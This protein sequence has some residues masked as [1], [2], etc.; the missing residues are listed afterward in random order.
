VRRKDREIADINEKLALL[1]KCKVCRLGLSVRDEPYVIPLNFGY[2]FADNRLTLYF[3]SAAEGKKSD[4][5]R[6]NPQACFETDTGHELVQADS[7]CGYGF[8]YAS[9]I[10]FGTIAIIT[11]KE[12][13]IHA[14]NTLMRHQTDQDKDF[15]FS[16]GEVN[17][18]LVYKLAVSEFTGK[19]Y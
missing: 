4:I 12:E 8:H 15:S 7:A 2:T 10:G 3:H 1:K 6:A 19:K 14:L 13:K 11:G 17:K 16:D 9:L 5:I 18:V